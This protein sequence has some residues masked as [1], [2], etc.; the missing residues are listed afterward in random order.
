MIPFP[1]GP[2][3]IIY[4]DPAW[5][6]DDTCDS[7]ERGAAH[8]YDVMTIDDLCA[9][10]VQSI[11]AKD[12]ALFLWM[13]MPKMRE[14]MKL[15]DAWQFTFKTVAFTWLKTTKHGKLF[16]GMGRWTRSNPELCWLATKG[17]PHRVD[18]AVHSV[19]E[20]PVTRHSE[21]P[22]EVR[23]RIVQLM[24]DISRVELFA[25]K[26]YRGWKAWGNE[27]T[28]YYEEDRQVALW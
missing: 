25:R 6:Y 7:G 17:H 4:A 18:A 12:C 16:T 27:L 24:G 20:A 3:D 2:F 13:T 8:K 26:R 19:I 15:I 10:P 21:K 9:L 11:A 23:E 5:E 22:N 28:T 14:A 1:E